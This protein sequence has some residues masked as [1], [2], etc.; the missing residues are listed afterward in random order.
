M[1]FLIVLISSLFAIAN[2]TKPTKGSVFYYPSGHS[3]QFVPGLIDPNA[4]AFGS[5]QQTSESNG[6]GQ[7]V[8]ESNINFETSVQAHAAG[9]LVSEEENQNCFH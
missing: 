3:Y 4:A 9:Y 5:F 2:A 7:L 1:S 6:W 8:I